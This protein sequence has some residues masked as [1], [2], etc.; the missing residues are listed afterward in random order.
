MNNAATVKT[1]SPVSKT[2][3]KPDIGVNF[4]AAKLILLLGK[5]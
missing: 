3:R 1:I 4:P 5:R 2:R